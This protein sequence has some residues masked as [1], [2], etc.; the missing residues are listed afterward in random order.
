MSPPTLDDEEESP[1]HWCLRARPIDGMTE[2]S[3]S[4][5]RRGSSLLRLGDLHCRICVFSA[6]ALGVV[7]LIARDTVGVSRLQQG[8]LPNW[9]IAAV[10]AGLVLWLTISSIM[11]YAARPHLRALICKRRGQICPFCYYDL[12]ARPLGE[13]TCSE[14][15]RYTP[16]RE[17]VRI[18]CKLVRHGV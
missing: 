8:V 1:R 11:I 2:P 4:H 14:C 12:T 3:M 18:W 10:I 15:G 17:C 7:F 5:L 13:T 16:R 6:A 9:V